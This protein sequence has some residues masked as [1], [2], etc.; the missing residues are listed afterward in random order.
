MFCRELSQNPQ[1]YPNLG[2]TPDQRQTAKDL[3]ESTFSNLALVQFKYGSSLE[4]KNPEREK[5]LTEA[6]KSATEALKINA[7]NAKALF[8]R[9]TA[10]ANLSYG[11]V[12]NEEAQKF[13][14][15]AKTDFIAV[16]KLEPNNR[17]ARSSLKSAQETFKK[18]KSE[19]VAMEKREFSFSG[20]LSGLGEKEK[21]VLGD[22]SIRKRQISPGN[23][24]VWFNDDWLQPDTPTRCVVHITASVKSSDDAKVL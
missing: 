17:E 22:G 6:V 7:E 15:D 1:Y 19:E 10:R 16:V 2:H 24:E 23:G 20:L 13:C 8:R 4:L 9:G 3:L 12:N 11:T 21:D 5:V 14:V 18:L